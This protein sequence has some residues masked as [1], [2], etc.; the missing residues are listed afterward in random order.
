MAARGREIHTALSALLDSPDPLHRLIASDALPGLPGRQDAHIAELERRLAQ[1]T[2][3]H[4]ATRLIYILSR[5]LQRDP[6]QVNDVLRRLSATP[7][8]AVLSASPAGEQPIG[9]ADQG[10]I[11]VSI[12]AA[13][14]AVYSTSFA[15]RTLD[16]WLTAPAD[17]A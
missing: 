11:G 13:L 10:S 8:W 1:E 7:R 4:V 12:I 5:Y 2:D 15:R 16:T 6:G 3:R 17:H 9:P 14:G